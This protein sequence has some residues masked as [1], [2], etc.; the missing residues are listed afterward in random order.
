V[1]VLGDTTRGKGSGPRLVAYRQVGEGAEPLHAGSRARALERVQLGYD[2]AGRPFGVIVSIDGVGV[3]TLHHPTWDDEVPELKAHGTRF[4]P[5]S[6][7]LDDAP[8]FER[9]FFV[10]ADEPFEVEAILA[11]AHQLAVD[12]LRALLEALPLPDRYEQTALT[13]LK[14]PF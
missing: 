12:P 2:A 11:A 8:G 10:S 13:L 9:F 3:V 14:A 1:L 7:E 4:L 6:F 5:F